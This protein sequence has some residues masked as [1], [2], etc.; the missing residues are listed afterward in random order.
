MAPL[1]ALTVWA[2]EMVF[3]CV[4]SRD[5]PS[6]S[7]SHRTT[8]ALEAS[9]CVTVLA[10]RVLAGSSG[11]H[12][13]PLLLPGVL[14][15]LRPRWHRLSPLS[16][17]CLG[18]FAHPRL[19]ARTPLAGPSLCLGRRLNPVGLYTKSI[20]ENISHVPSCPVCLPCSH[21]CPDRQDQAY[22]RA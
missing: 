4:P 5:A 7:E 22:V 14:L 17:P 10:A 8:P 15:R 3:S 2:E 9:S 16:Q 13:E 11:A 18:T 12:S 21:A 20:L 6:D 1:L 19:L